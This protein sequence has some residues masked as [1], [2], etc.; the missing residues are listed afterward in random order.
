MIDRLPTIKEK[1]IELAIEAG[2][3]VNDAVGRKLD[4]ILGS[5]PE[6]A[7]PDPTPMTFVE[8]CKLSTDCLP[9]AL[10]R[11]RLEALH[12]EMLDEIERLHRGYGR[13]LTDEEIHDCFQNRGRDGLKTRKLIAAAIEAMLREKNT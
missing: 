3:Y 8:R 11:T 12:Q 9:D 4:H 6:I 2:G 5:M 1:I 13:G 7:A 10:Y